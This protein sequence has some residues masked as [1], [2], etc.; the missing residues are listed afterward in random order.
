M[1]TSQNSPLVLGGHSFISQLGN[2]PCLSVDGQFRLIEACLNNGIT[3]FDT[4]YQPE[5]IALGRCL[6]TLGRRDEATLIAWNFFT[7]FEAGDEVGGP[8]YYEAHHIQQ[9][10]D[11]LRT[12]QIDYLV[13]HAMDDP[14]ENARQEALACEWQSQGKALKLGTWAPPSDILDLYD[15]ENPYSF[16]VHPRNITTDDADTVFAGAKALGWE[17]LA[18]SPFVRGW[19]L[20]RIVEGILKIQ[21]GEAHTVRSKTA[22]LLLRY[23][24]FQPD[25]DRLIVAMRDVAWV[26]E[27]VESIGAGPLADEELSWLTSQCAYMVQKGP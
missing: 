25:V 3:W 17:T 13:V 19:E 20:D 15:E 9:M 21:G 7:E 27:N 8:D 5:R 23:A 2:E 26:A 4:T 18:C 10:L 14:E 11:E 24:F 16:M 6:D 12:D 22:S 1:T